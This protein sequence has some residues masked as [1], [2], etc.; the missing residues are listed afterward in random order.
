MSYKIEDI[1]SLSLNSCKDKMYSGWDPYDGLN[2]K[3][4][5]VLP[6]TNSVLFRM[7]WIQLFKHSPI[8]LRKLLLVEQGENPKGLALILISYCNI[9][10]FLS[11]KNI[12]TVGSWSKESLLLEINYISNRILELRSPN[13]D[14]F[15][16]GYNFPWQSKAFYLPR[17]CPTVVASSFVVDGLLRAYDITGEPAL[18]S[19]SIS[20]SEFVRLDLNHISNGD[21]IGFSY[22]PLDNRLVYNASL[23]GTRLLANVYKYTNDPILLKFAKKSIDSTLPAFNKDGSID[24]S[25]QVGKSWRDNFHTGFKLESLAR[26]I[27]YTNDNSYEYFL[28]EAKKYWLEN[29]FSDDGTC[30]YFDDSVYPLDIHCPGQFFST[31]FHIDKDKEY[32]D[33]A[34]NVYKWMLDTF[35][36]RDKNMFL[37]QKK[38]HY[39]INIPYMRWGQAWA[40][41]GLSFYLLYKD[42]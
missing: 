26:Y 23:L 35:Y 30:H 39:K 20:C 19:A 29:F 27:D 3:V 41:Y 25:I 31:L 24:H 12:S 17:W 2:S 36:S 9:Y 15:C 13:F 11:L 33:L 16:W 22:S 6:F 8:N 7:A 18:L 38:K 37:F 14:N 34:E 21:G 1:L 5:D 10:D 4:F 32:A 40:I 28:L 42:V